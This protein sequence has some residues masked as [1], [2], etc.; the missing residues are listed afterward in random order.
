MMEASQIHCHVPQVHKKCVE[1]MS[2]KSHAHI[3]TVMMSRSR[4]ARSG[5]HKAVNEFCIMETFHLATCLL[6][7]SSPVCVWRGVGG[8]QRGGCVCGGGGVSWG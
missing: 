6:T 4:K 5:K 1:H 7:R 3:I 2:C 8:G